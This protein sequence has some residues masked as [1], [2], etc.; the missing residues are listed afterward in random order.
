MPALSSL[1]FHSVAKTPTGSSNKVATFFLSPLVISFSCSTNLSKASPG[2]FLGS[3]TTST[4][5]LTPS[6]LCAFRS[7][8]IPVFFAPLAAKMILSSVITTRVFVTSRPSNNIL[9]TDSDG[10]DAL[11]SSASPLGFPHP[12]TIAP[13][14]PHTSFFHS[15]CNSRAATQNAASIFKLIA[16]HPV[17]RLDL[18]RSLRRPIRSKAPQQHVERNTNTATP[19]SSTAA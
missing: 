16:D 19:R 6:G 7:L 10:V 5:R 11:S 13:A 8:K 18:I 17:A 3:S 9:L 15:A 2:S 4:S 12:T 14:P 1:A